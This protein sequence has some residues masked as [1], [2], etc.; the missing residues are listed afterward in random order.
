MSLDVVDLL[1]YFWLRYY[2]M[3]KWLLSQMAQFVSGRFC[4]SPVII[5]L[6]II[7][8]FVV[9]PIVI[10]QFVSGQFGV[11]QVIICLFVIG[12]FVVKP[13]IICLIVICQ[14]VFAP[15]LSW[16]EERC[17]LLKKCFS[18]HFETSKNIN[19]SKVLSKSLQPSFS[20]FDW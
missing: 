8:R 5:C 13:I 4:A 3:A 9:I 12:Q 2:S 7:G 14:L 16:R 19:L 11:S 6:S 15:N 20:L 17:F 18:N 1:H 10:C